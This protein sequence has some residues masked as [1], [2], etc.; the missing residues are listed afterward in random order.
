MT[1][2]DMTK[3]SDTRMPF[4]PTHW[5]SKDDIRHVT[6]FWELKMDQNAL[7]S[8]AKRSRHVVRSG[9]CVRVTSPTRSAPLPLHPGRPA[10]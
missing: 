1:D 3:V 7:L 2:R 4:Q 5:V 9:I 6:R 10:G 8:E